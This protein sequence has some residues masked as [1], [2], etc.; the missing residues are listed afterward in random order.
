[1]QEELLTNTLGE[2]IARSDIEEYGAEVRSSAHGEL[3]GGRDRERREEGA[4]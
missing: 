1:M 2:Y 3:A 4:Q